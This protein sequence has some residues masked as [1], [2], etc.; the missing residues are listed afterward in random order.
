MY[1]DFPAL[2]RFYTRGIL[3]QKSGSFFGISP[4]ESPASEYTFIIANF[5]IFVNKMT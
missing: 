5:I 2:L 3:V 4:F 1:R